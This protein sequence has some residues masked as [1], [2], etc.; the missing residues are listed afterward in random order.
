MGELSDLSW[1]PGVQSNQDVNKIEV[2]QEKYIVKLLGDFGMIESKT[3]FTPVLENVPIS[4]FDDCLS[5]GSKEEK[6]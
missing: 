3:A 1:F 5:K 6:E 4:S 2:S